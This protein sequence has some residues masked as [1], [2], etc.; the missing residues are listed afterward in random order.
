[1]RLRTL[2][3]IGLYLLGFF[4]SIALAQGAGMPLPGTTPTPSSAIPS[5]P[6]PATES[7]PSTSAPGA[8]APASRGVPA[9]ATEQLQGSI[10]VPE[11]AVPIPGLAPF[12]APAPQGSGSQAYLDLPYLGQYI[13]AVYTYALGVAVTLATVMVVIG[14]LKWM[15]ARGDSSKVSDAKET[16]SRAIIGMFL[17]L[18][19]YTV[20]KF[21]NPEL[22]NLRALRIQVVERDELEESLL[23][24]TGDTSDP[25]EAAPAGSA[26]AAGSGATTG[27]TSGSTGASANLFRECPVTLPASTT[28]TPTEPRSE[29][30]RRLIPTVVTG[31]TPAERAAQIASA[32]EK[33]GVYLGCCL[34]AVQDFYRLAG[35]RRGPQTNTI[36]PEQLSWLRTQKCQRG[37]ECNINERK[38][39]VFNRF[40]GEITNWPNSYIEDLQPGDSFVIFNA[41]SIDVHGNHSVFFVGWANQSQ[42]RARVIQGSPGRA[43]RAGTVCLTTACGTPSPLVR[44]FRT[45]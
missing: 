25:A 14:G 37:T 35:A 31:A 27:A 22:V 43:V 19:S 45:R 6:A 42:G 7:T 15:L 41:N 1:M 9:S 26:G 38:L 44:T 20:L 17:I 29:E 12:E 11:L 2:L 33:C 18:G 21:I 40:Q 34:C 36:N 13:N 8:T 30:F 24:T 32:A 5:A 28:R 23:A 10:G 16:L 39:A 4:P 3:A